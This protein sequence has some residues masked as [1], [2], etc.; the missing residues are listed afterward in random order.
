MKEVEAIVGLYLELKMN[1]IGVF[2]QVRLMDFEKN[3]MYL[4]KEERKVIFLYG[5]CNQTS[6]ESSSVL[7]VHHSTVIDKYN[8]AVDKLYNLMNGE[9]E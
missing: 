8:I 6:R 2:G 1:R 5:I 4:T 7:S 3:L 9:S